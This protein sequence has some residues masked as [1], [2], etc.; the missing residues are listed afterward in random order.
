[1][2][3]RP[4]MQLGGQIEQDRYV[5]ALLNG[6]R[7]GTFVDIGCGPPLINSNTYLLEVHFGWTGIAVDVTDQRDALQWS[8][9]PGTRHI[10]QDAATI[11][12]AAL[13]AESFPGGEI[14]FL[15]LDLE[16]PDI[17]YDVLRVLPWESWRPHVIAYEADAYRDVEAAAREQEAAAFLRSIGYSLRA[18]LYPRLLHLLT[19]NV[20]CQDHIWMRADTLCANTRGEF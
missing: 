17:T 2:S 12:Y 14:D 20:G 1:M 16:P 7:N 15:S 9:R 18:R 19:E 13:F 11:D 10:V 6:K 8:D 4:D 5:L 3:S